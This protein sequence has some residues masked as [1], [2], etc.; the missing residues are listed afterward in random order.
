MHAVF[1]QSLRHAL[2]GL[3]RLAINDA[4]FFRARAEKIQQLIVR[5]VFGDDAIGQVRAVET[6][7]VTFRLAQFQMRDDV[8]AHAPGRGGGERHE[9]DVGKMFSQFGNLA[10]FRTEIVAPFADAMR[11]VNGDEFHVPALQIGQK[12]GKH[13]PLR[14]DVEQTEFA[15]V[16][17][18]QAFAAFAR[19]ERRIQKRRRDAAGLQ[20]VHLVF[21]QRN[22]RRNHDREAVARE[23][24]QAGSKAICRRRSAAAQRH[25]CPRAN[26]G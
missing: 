20:R 16:Q 2:G 26:R 17:A 24:G 22:Q 6:G 11:L 21:H 18:A 10:V 19:R 7:D 5:L 9:R 23:R 15:I 14:R 8:L 4:A 1:A 12:S 13:Q 3:A 25:P